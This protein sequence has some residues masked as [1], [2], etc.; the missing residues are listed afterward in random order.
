MMKRQTGFTVI[1][2][3]IT[4]VV[5]VFAI[6]AASRIFTGLLTQFKQQS[7]IAETN[8]EGVVGLDILRKDIAHAGLGL[9]WNV[10][11]V[12]DT[13][14]DGNLWDEVPGYTEA[15]DV[16]YNDA[17]NNQPSAFKNGDGANAD[18]SDR[19]VIKSASAAIIAAA[20]K[21]TRLKSAPPYVRTWS[22][23]TEDLGGTDR[24]IV[25]SPGATETNSRSLVVSGGPFHT[26]YN[27]VS[28]YAPAD[29]TD[30]RLVYGIS[31]ANAANLLRA[32]FNRADYYLSAANVPTRCAAGTS[33]LIKA[34][35]N[36]VTGNLDEM[37][38]LDCV[39]DMQAVYAMDNDEDGDFENGVGGDAYTNSLAGLTSEQIR[40]RIREVQV[41]ILAHE[42]QRDPDFTFNNFSAAHSVTV[43]RSA[44][45]GHDF[46]FDLAA[47]PNFLNYRWKL[48]TISVETDN[49]R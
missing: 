5:F 18:G 6:A 7:K 26:Q 49:L 42:G 45:L 11:G 1:E 12:V 38:I 3:M 39:A 17:P 20:G 27:T 29:D 8:I 40:T 47:I 43:G 37:P 48:Y 31:P 13:N 23:Y 28:A 36:H 15:T 19:L 4:M 33:V 16:T 2:L 9:P 35:L 46:D 34:T 21:N 41:F 44:A 22:L 14:G 10:T 32:P 25:L 30:V 24:V